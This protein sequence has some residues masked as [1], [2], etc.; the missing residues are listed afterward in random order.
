ML[1]T[2][3]SLKRLQNHVHVSKTKTCFKKLKVDRQNLKN[4]WK[5]KWKNSGGAKVIVL[6]RTINFSLYENYFFTKNQKSDD[7]ISM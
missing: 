4:S 2:M 1:Y 3:N 6:V 5:N 7:V